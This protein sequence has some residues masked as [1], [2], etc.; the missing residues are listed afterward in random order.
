VNWLIA[1]LALVFRRLRRTRKVARTRIVAPG[2]PRPRAE[3]VV[4]ALFGLAALAA[5]AV[6]P[7][8]AF[9]SLRPHQTQ[10]LGLAFGLA[11]AALAA[12]C[13]VIA[14]ALVPQ[15]EIAEPYT[16]P[17]RGREQVVVEQIVEESGT[18]FT[19]RRLVKLA[20]GGAGAALGAALVTPAL[21]LGPALDVAQLRR[22]AWRRGVKLVDGDGK[23]LRADDVTTKTLFTAYPEG[24]DKD[25]LGSPLVVVRV[26]PAQLEL[27]DDRRAWAP[28]GIL[29]Y[30]KICTHAGCAVSLYRTPTFEPTSSR[31]AL[32]CPCHYSTFDP[33]RG[34]TVLFGPAGRNLPQLPLEIDGDGMLRAAGDFSGP[35]GPSWWGVRWGNQHAS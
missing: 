6:I 8:Y 3:S 30:S 28:D 11:F 34:G 14:K 10:L 9:D 5:A 19:R 24:A 4:L 22:T 25:A 26:D 20:A 32:V 2:S 17:E 13:I 16:E 33:A 1:L 31:P 7:I 29:A 35:I 18:R 21:S 15:E 12:A 27:P 23:P